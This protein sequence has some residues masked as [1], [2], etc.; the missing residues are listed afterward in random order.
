MS[1][2]NPSTPPTEQKKKIKNKNP[3]CRETAEEEK[4][5]GSIEE[6]IM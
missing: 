6:H 2:I 4:W 5:F 3:Y 1:K